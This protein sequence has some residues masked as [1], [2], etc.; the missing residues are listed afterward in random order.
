MLV[1]LSWIRDYLDFSLTN[2]QIADTL[3]LAGLEVDKVEP[4][5]LGFE[6]VVV[7]RVID[8]K[9][10]PEAD[11]LKVATVSD[12]TETFQVVCGAPNCRKN[13]ITSF[14]KIGAK[15]TT[16]EDK[17]FKIKKSKLRGVESFGM[18]CSET[19][20]NLGQDS[21][22]IMELED[23]LE[24]G[25]CL[26]KIYGDTL[27]EISLTP[28]LGHCT[29]IKGIARELAALLNLQLK[30]IPLEIQETKDLETEQ[31]VSLSI[32]DNEACDRFCLRY[33]E[34]IEIA[35]SPAW[36]QKR[37]ESCGIR[38]INNVVDVTNYVMLAT[39]QP[40]HAYDY[41][42]ISGGFIKVSKLTNKTTFVSLD[43]E[44]RELPEGL[45]VIEDEEKILGLAGVIGSQSSSVTDYT[46][47]LLLEAAHFNPSE[48]RKSSKAI[49]LRTDASSR[50]EKNTDPN[51]P[52]EALKMACHLLQQ[53][54]GAKVSETFL[55]A[56]QQPFPKRNLSLRIEKT[57]KLLGTKLSQNEIL[58]IFESLDFEPSLAN[59]DLIELNIPTYRNDIQAEIDLIEEVARLYGYNNI[60]FSYETCRVSQ[61]TNNPIYELEKKAR[62]YLLRESLQECITCNLISPK[63]AK[64]SLEYFPHESPLIEVLKPSSVDQS[65]LRPSLLPGLLQM[66]KHNFDRQNFSI[67]SFELGQIHYKAEG[68]FHE[69]P[70]AAIL[71]T[72]NNSPQF[73]GSKPK[74][75][76][77]FDL[78][79]HVE[80]VLS[81]FGI[82]TYKVS[83]SLLPGFHPGRRCHL[84]AENGVLLATLGEVHPGVLNTLDIKQ[85]VFFAELNLPSVLQLQN[86]KRQFQQLPQYPGTERDWTKTFPATMKANNILKA[87]NNIPSKLLKGVS[88][89][90]LYVDEKLGEQKNLTFRF[91]YRDERKTLSH[92]SV[93]KEHHRILAQAE[94]NLANYR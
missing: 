54:A 1:P 5:D 64:I 45:L 48:I 56:K 52:L 67:Q 13:L 75:I 80:N 42:K 41:D 58:Q 53:I 34:D 28:N 9:P 92:E 3:T 29:S 11:K 44:T 26:K 8:T 94:S 91:H 49:H 46:R 83:E 7:G 35:P 22:G 37:I 6:G 51:A 88:L 18:L 93:E 27:F 81:Q 24:L 16:E 77:F 31:K 73:W 39:G 87:L 20:L 79:G 17:V 38:P 30:T 74:E 82:E 70:S 47:N 19:E 36:L 40:M 25:T 68:V 2:E 63:L 65:I 12:G 84:E 10:H 66:V 4:T 72:G 69:Q 71:L 60:D 21:D 62:K 86:Q 57:N 33:L 90:D 85:R 59:D 32:E 14:A 78:K 55:D 43:E 50:F 15:L 89:L 76:D 23:T 61:L